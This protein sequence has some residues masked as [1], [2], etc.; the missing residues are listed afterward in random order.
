MSAL[1]ELN[2]HIINCRRCPRLVEYR[3][4][5][6]R[7][8]VRRY[9][10]WEYWGRPV[11]GFGDPEARLLVIGLA[12]AAHGGNRT[13]RVF[14]GA[15]SGDF[16]YDALFE[17]GFASKPKAVSRDDGLELLDCYIAAAVRCAPPD[18]KPNLEEFTSC[19]P[20]L[21]QELRLLAK[22]KAVLV[23]G[24][25]AFST[26]LLAR[27]ELGLPVPRPTLK[28]GH[29]AR[30]LLPDGMT[31]LASYHPS[32]QNTQTGR[33]TRAMFHDVFRMTR[34]TL[35]DRNNEEIKV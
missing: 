9:R 32:Q 12:P 2:T 11:P 26:Y 25:I 35:F 24:Q 8:K 10:D 22:L 15:K 14:T 17:H 16:L 27:K 23:L 3:E 1:E 28:F 20:Y 19:R 31:L 6:A 18:N 34:E 30:Y 29:G 4:E 21:L 5:V 33:L 13:G 7:T